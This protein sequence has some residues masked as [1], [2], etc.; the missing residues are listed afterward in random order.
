[1]LTDQRPDRAALALSFRQELG[2][3]LTESKQLSNE[4]R[5]VVLRHLNN[6]RA[7]GLVLQEMRDSLSND[8]FQKI[9]DDVDLSDDAI[10]NFVAFARKHKEGPIED[11]T[12]G[13]RSAFESALRASGALPMPSG[14]G[15]QLSH[16]PPP[17]LTW[18]GEFVMQFKVRFSKYLAAKPLHSWN[19]DQAEQFLYGLKPLLKVHKQVADWLRTQSQ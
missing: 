2:A 10:R 15:P 11:F 8:A 5:D 17:F 16:D 19:R 13:I 1:M 6:T 18:A 7:T 4:I 12:I 3:R 14:F 9:V